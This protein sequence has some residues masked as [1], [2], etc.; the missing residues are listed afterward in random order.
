M[1][2]IEASVVVTVCLLCINPGQSAWPLP[3]T[4]V[5]DT[6]TLGRLKSGRVQEIV[7]DVAVSV[8]VV[9]LAVIAPV[10]SKYAFVSLH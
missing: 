7:T 3:V 10:P 1:N 2:D 4:R 6:L 9:I 8:D 5:S